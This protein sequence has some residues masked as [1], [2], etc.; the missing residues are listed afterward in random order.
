M[1]T[2]DE[3][4]ARETGTRTGLGRRSPQH[5]S[6]RQ[7]LDIP[8]SAGKKVLVRKYN[9]ASKGSKTGS[10]RRAVLQA[11]GGREVHWNLAFAG[12]M[13]W[14]FVEYSRLPEMYPLFQVLALGKVTTL[15]AAVGFMLNSRLRASGSPDSKGLDLAI[16]IFMV[17]AF[18]ST[19][20]ASQQDQVWNS[21]LDVV[22]W[23]LIYF[24]LSRIMVNTWQVRALLFLVFLLNLKLAQHTIRS[25]V[26]DRSMGIPD[27]QIILTGGAG[28]GTSSFFGNVADLGLAMAV[29]WGITW[30][31]L[32]GKTEKKK[33]NRRFLVV[34]FVGFLLAILFCGSRGAVV[35]AAAIA[36]VALGK[37][38]KKIGAMVLALI[39]VLGVWFVLPNASKER[40]K[41]AWNW[42][43]DANAASRVMFWKIGLGMFEDNPILGVGPGNFPL[44]NPVHFVSH[45]LYIQVLSEQGLVGTLSLA[46]ILVL[47]FRLNARTR[48][49]ALATRA[50]GRQSIEYCMA[51]GLDLALV[52]YLT[53]GAFLSVLYYPHLWVLLGLSVA[54]NR[55]LAN[56]DT[57]VQG[58]DSK[59]LP[60]RSRS[61]ALATP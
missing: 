14:G 30:A 12:L 10:T 5:S 18:L 53:S 7:G 2:R 21:F 51:L 16:V 15:L 22:T 39:F 13:L 36:L 44:V 26:V 45:S 47:F 29:V 35:G 61:V 41:S 48:K 43:Q 33:W 54:V 42:Q 3:I 31:L 1:L 24:L 52:G 46:A 34:C 28:E 49:R 4:S 58:Q 8:F 50:A 38:T 9:P 19:C 6:A 59:S 27:M 40:F 17:G 11:L 32:L 55:C 56:R 37:S 25:Y 60:A 57:E 23:G 20:F